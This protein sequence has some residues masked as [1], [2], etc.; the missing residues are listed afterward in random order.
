MIAFD[1]SIVDL[2]DELSDPVEVLFGIQLG[3]G[4]DIDQALGYCQTLVGNPS[5]TVLVLDD[6]PLRGRRPRVDAATRRVA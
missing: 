2:T 5:K 3:G 1:T 4:T 6:R